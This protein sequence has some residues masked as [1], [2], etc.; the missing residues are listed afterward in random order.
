MN[1]IQIPNV[2]NIPINDEG[3]PDLLPVAWAILLDLEKRAPGY[4]YKILG[5]LDGEGGWFQARCEPGAKLTVQK[6]CLG[7]KFGGTLFFALKEL[8]PEQMLA[9]P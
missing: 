8:A 2:T 5:N 3:D 6:E 1:D 4:R 9:E 7:T